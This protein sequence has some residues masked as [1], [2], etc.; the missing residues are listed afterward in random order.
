MEAVWGINEGRPSRQLYVL[1]L[2]VGKKDLLNIKTKIHQESHFADIFK[3]IWAVNTGPFLENY[4]IPKIQCYI[5]L[6]TF[7]CV[8]QTLLCRQIIFAYKF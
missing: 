4:L 6:L 7:D 5:L 2:R 8:P 3:K 1:N